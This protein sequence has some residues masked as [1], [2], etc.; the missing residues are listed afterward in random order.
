MRAS[1]PAPEYLP[2]PLRMPPPPAPVRPHPVPRLVPASCSDI[3]GRI[4]LLLQGHLYHLH[5]LATT[6]HRVQHPHQQRLH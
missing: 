3:C 6:F 2:P 4:H 1:P 5:R